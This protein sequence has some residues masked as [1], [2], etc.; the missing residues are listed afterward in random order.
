[1][2]PG[3]TGIDIEATCKRLA[4]YISQSGYSDKEL[5]QM[6]CT[7]VQSV[8]KW[9]HGHN[10]P[11]IDNMYRLSRILGIKIDDLIVPEGYEEYRSLDDNLG[12]IACKVRIRRYFLMIRNLLRAPLLFGSVPDSKVREYS[13]NGLDLSVV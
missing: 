1:M 6:L 10:I 2:F 12:A 13:I 7:S 4:C 3:S 11:D 5:A 9:R 8:N